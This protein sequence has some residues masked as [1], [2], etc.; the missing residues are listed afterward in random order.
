MCVPIDNL[1]WHEMLSNAEQSYQLERTLVLA[2]A[3]ATLDELGLL[4]TVVIAS[5]PGPLQTASGSKNRREVPRFFL[6]PR[7]LFSLLLRDFAEQWIED[8]MLLG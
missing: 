4:S 1:E 6:V 8:M 2:L 5:T 7:L 3:Q